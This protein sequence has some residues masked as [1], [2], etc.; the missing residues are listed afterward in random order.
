MPE[1]LQRL[2]RKI[3][4]GLEAVRELK[5][6]EAE[7]KKQDRPKLR[8]IKGSAVGAAL[9]AGVEWLWGYKVTVAVATAA[10]AFTGGVIADHPDSPSADPPQVV[11]PPATA[12]PS[13]PPRPKATPTPRRT[14]PPRTQVPA[15]IIPPS[16]PASI[17]PTVKPKEKPKVTPTPSRTTAQPPSSNP[18]VSLPVTPTVTPSVP[19]VSTTPKCTVDLLG[20]K[21]CLPLGGS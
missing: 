21:L 5:R 14:S 3:E 6:L 7:Q 11:T 4:E 19:V 2:Q 20:I 9:W 10:V 15:R 8:L 12:R 17:K 18:A 1:D 13:V 16:V